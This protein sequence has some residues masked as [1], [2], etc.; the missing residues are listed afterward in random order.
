MA[1]AYAL[2][3]LGKD[4]RDRQPRPGAAGAAA[5]PG[6]RP[7]IEIA[8]RVDGRLRR[9]ASSWSAATWRAPASTGS[10]ATS[11]STSTIT[12]A[13]RCTAR[14]TGSTRG[15]AACGEMVFD[16]IQALGVP[17]TPEIATH[18]YVAILTDTGSFH[19]SNISPRTFD[20]CR[21]TLEAGVDPVAVARSVFDSNNI[22]RLRLFGAV[23]EPVELDA[24]GPARD[25][26]PRP[27][28][29]ARGRRHL[30]RHRG[31]D[32]PAAHREGNPGRRLLQGGR[33]PTSTASACA[34]RAT[35]TSATSRKQFGGGGHKNAAGCTVDGTL[36]RGAGAGHP[37]GRRGD[38]A[39]GNGD[40]R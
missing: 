12:P 29:G 28:D 31:P 3:A 39:A 26:L 35:S 1:M 9:R 33:A 2:R 8:D 19:Y 40:V 10:T 16:V 4:V 18:I 32:Q 5:V 14:S 27:G 21:Q 15:A 7:T 23:L 37:A 36:R 38:R 13:T 17:L 30:R 20:I 22:G 24:I 34:R 6:R 25:D 11:S